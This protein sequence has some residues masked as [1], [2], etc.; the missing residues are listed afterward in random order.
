MGGGVGRIIRIGR[1]PVNLQVEAFDNVV[2]PDDAPT[3][4]WTLRLQVQFLFP[5]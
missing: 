1:L 5:K 3:P 2:K 4:D